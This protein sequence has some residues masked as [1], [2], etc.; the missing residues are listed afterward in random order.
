M[1]DSDAAD[2]D[3]AA[4]FKMTIAYDGGAY[5]GWQVQ[6]N[7]RTIQ[8]ELERAVHSVG[9][10]SV[11]VTASGRTDAGVHA[12]GQVVSFQVETDL[13][14]ETWRRALNAN[15]PDDIRVLAAER[16]PRFHAIR[17][18]IGKRYRYVLQDGEP[19]NLFLRHYA[20]RTRR[21]LE[22]EAMRQAA[23]RLLGRHDF[24]SFEAAGAPRADSVRT[25]HDITV[26]RPPHDAAQ[27]WIEIEAD[28]FLYNMVR[29][30]VGSLEVIGAG[31][32]P[33]AWIEEV[34]AARDRK[35]AAATAPPQG[36]FLIRVDYPES[37]DRAAWREERAEQGGEGA[38]L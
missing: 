22:L 11:R 9:G 32:Q 33:V 24:S 14:A 16:R 4:C 15:L 27:L 13:P 8:G 30:I 29:N 20:W 21:P 23:S 25:I 18:A 10:R 38:N 3:R 7:G 34:L 37:T 5:C 28:G 36:L 2:L 6:P 12:T 19:E 26:E 35:R 17:D 1:N 31:K